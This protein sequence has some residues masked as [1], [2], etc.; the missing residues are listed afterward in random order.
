MTNSR[1]VGTLPV[2]AADWSLTVPDARTRN[3]LHELLHLTLV[4]K[5][6]VGCRGLHVAQEALCQLLTATAGDMPLLAR[7]PI[8]ENESANNQAMTEEIVL[9]CNQPPVRNARA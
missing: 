3:R 4:V 8:S 2:C 5:A 9:G 6:A 7:A 1:Q